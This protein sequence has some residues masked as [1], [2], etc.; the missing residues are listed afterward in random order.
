MA[1]M[2]ARALAKTNLPWMGA[3]WEQFGD[4]IT[5]DGSYQVTTKKLT[6][7]ASGTNWGWSGRGMASAT[8][9][10]ASSISARAGSADPTADLITVL[11]GTNDFKLNFPIGTP[12]DTARTTFYGAYKY[13]MDTI[14]TANPDATILLMTPMQRNNAGYDTNFVNTAG[15]K[16]IDYVDAVFEIGKMYAVP[17]LDLYRIS[18]ISP[19]T[20]VTFLA[21]GLHPNGL[22]YDRLGRII[23]RA[24]NRL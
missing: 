7:I 4:S 2:I 22:G 23:A 18:G 17:I 8:P 20:Y 6:G 19:N 5:S 11:G 12:T 9:D 24:L 15:H 10:G 1:D 16:L 21:D 14:I 13:F 3:K